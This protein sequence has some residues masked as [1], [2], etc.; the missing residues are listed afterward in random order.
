MNPF[1]LSRIALLLF[2]SLLYA[3]VSHA[4]STC[5]CGDPTLTLMGAEKPF[6]GRLRLGLD[7]MWRSETQGAADNPAQIETREQR[8]TLGL[9]YSPNRRLTLAMQLPYVSKTTQRR[10]LARERSRGLGDADISARLQLYQSGPL[11]G[12]HLIGASAGLRL[13]TSDQVDNQQG[14]R[15]DID[16]QPDAGA[17]APTAGLWYG[18]YRFPWFATLS[19]SYRRFNDGRQG[20]EPGNAWVGSLLGQYAFSTTWAVQTGLDW[21]ASQ[22]NRFDGAIDA[23]S[24]GELVMG[25]LGLTRRFGEDLLLNLSAQLPVYEQLNGA[26]QEDEMLRLHLIYDL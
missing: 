8:S 17:Y 15:L 24:G 21:R 26:Q 6:A 1:S 18:Y 25:R 9:V 14:Q 2:G 13:P 4:C 3:P 11:S 16:A 23:D 10:N 5:K 7:L 12:R 19:S 20:F 22:K